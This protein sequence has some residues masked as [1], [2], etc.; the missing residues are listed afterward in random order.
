MAGR[1]AGTPGNGTQSAAARDRAP[2]GL[3][4]SMRQDADDVIRAGQ[5]GGGCNPGRALAQA[6]FVLMAGAV[7]FIGGLA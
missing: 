7:R 5:F 4:G 3:R 2:V 1:I 6:G